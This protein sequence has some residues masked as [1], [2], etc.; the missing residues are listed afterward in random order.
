M[1]HKRVQFS[2]LK[3]NGFKSFVD[4]TELMISPGVTGIVGPNGCGKSNLVEALRWVMGENSAK[5]IRGSEMDDV[6]FAGTATRSARNSA[7]VELF[8]ENPE[9]DAPALYNDGRTVR[10]SRHI[11]RGA[12]SSFRINEKEVRARDQQLLFADASSG[13]RSTAIV[14][15]GQVGAVINAKPNQ[16]RHL[17]EEAAGITGLHSR[18]HE[19]E[20]R[21]S[22]AEGN[23][24][25]LDDLLVALRSQLQSLK[26][27]ARQA[28]RYRSLSGRIRKAEA[29]LLYSRWTSL[30]SEAG[31]ASRQLRA[32][33]AELVAY[34]ASAASAATN[35]T[36]SAA[37]LPELRNKESE[38]ASLVHRL[39]TEQERLEEEAER[40]EQE[41]GSLIS[42]LE[43]VE[44]DKERETVL[45]GESATR[46]AEL[47]MEADKLRSSETKDQHLPG[48][49]RQAVGTQ[50]EAVAAKEAMAAALTE[51]L[52]AANMARNNLEQRVLKL[53][54]QYSSLVAKKST[55]AKE[56][57][58]IEQRKNGSSLRGQREQLAALQLSGRAL[59]EASEAASAERKAAGNLVANERQLVFENN[60][61]LQT[62][63][64][65]L[66]RLKAELS[67]LE[68]VLSSSGGEQDSLSGETASLASQ[69]EIAE[70]YEQALSA[71][72]GD[73]LGA[74]SK[75]GSSTTWLSVDSENEVPDLP[76]GLKILSE[77]VAGPPALERRL[78][79]I[80]LVSDR[81]QG[82]ELFGQLQQGQRLVTREGD[83]WR[84]DGFNRSATAMPSIAQR[85]KQLRRVGLLR[86]QISEGDGDY[87]RKKARHQEL[88]LRL[89]EQE[90]EFSSLQQAEERVR[91][92]VRKH[93]DVVVS[94]SRDLSER[95]ETLAEDIARL[96][97]LQ[98]TMEQ[99]AEAIE[100]L[101]VER[102]SV[103][104]ELDRLPDQ[105]NASN[106]LEEERSLLAKYR[107]ELET[108][109]R[110]QDQVLRSQEVR[111]ERLKT[112]SEE[113]TLWKSRGVGAEHQI[114]A[115]VLRALEIQK[116]LKS[117][118]SR[119][120]ELEEKKAG[121]L[122]RVGLAERQRIEAAE[123]LSEADNKLKACE[124]ALKLADTTLSD[125]REIKARLEGKREQAF[126][127]R[128]VEEQQIQER[129]GCRPS[130]TLQIA[131]ISS[132]DQ[133][134]ELGA[135]EKQMERL[136][137]ERENMGAVNLR[138]EEEAGELSAQLETLE[139][140]RDELLLAVSR[141][142]TGIASLN[143]E[144]RQ[145]LLGAF[146]AVNSHFEKLFVRLF[147][148]GKAK[149]SLI[150]SDDPLE[151]GLE[152][153]ASPPGKRLQ[154]LSLMSGGEKALAALSLLFA[155]F[156]TKPAPICV[157]DEV[158]APLD[159]ANVERFCQLV[160]EIASQGSTR[161]LVITHHRL[162]MAKMDRLFGV[163]MG[164]SGV[165]QL[166][167][168]DLQLGS[169]LEAAE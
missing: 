144:G 92:N 6:I 168:V 99:I 154:T 76:A 43:I 68:S 159:D 77:F 128:S 126:A 18:R 88:E 58:D 26:R 114:E 17:L 139:S 44:A 85:A 71:A 11:E 47:T 42:Q 81:E 108:E 98:N 15:Q 51:Q 19:A 37:V 1:G 148:G 115:L 101:H 25:R 111:A 9:R 121:L 22:A 27:Q 41:I 10:V 122:D 5:Q 153:M 130:D 132:V 157:L 79:Q 32:V 131:E 70:G 117:C 143:R 84:W 142:R 119:P 36:N 56:K 150:G 127:L 89:R 156:L 165:S 160:K 149:L 34:A 40:V 72:L 31:E 14:S 53:G 100:S 164:E 20:L 13:A 158:D 109:L 66:D 107:L 138:A 86:S 112:I 87:L 94:S 145:R 57:E 152:I 30:D 129:L 135:L 83:F 80:G 2:R 23:I 49:A 102:D 73:D 103:A 110:Q 140:E 64:L 54:E 38:A 90:G 8:L 61:D 91:E 52:V 147:G 167:S 29:M 33:E 93:E 161:F 39:S 96:R 141:L 82:F 105:E 16:R 48:L 137:R 116:L 4:P 113:A 123:V 59:R 166:V 78:S 67:A 151:A 74:S 163:T 50:R 104:T 63:V 95:S 62:T 136:L 75:P 46:I 12:G 146:D 155:V 55:L 28:S 125:C 24:E 35:Q 60:Q 3:L 45:H 124:Q 65:L 7:S 133:L 106:K 69:V 120:K 134:P 118:R 97:V 162:T 169:Q 21:L